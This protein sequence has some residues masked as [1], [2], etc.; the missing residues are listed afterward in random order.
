MIRH[1]NVTIYGKVQGVFFR[2]T[3]KEKADT[4][5]IKVS[6]ENK[7]DGT[8]YIEAEGEKEKLDEFIKWCHLGPSL[9]RVEKVE[10]A[11]SKLKNF[12]GFETF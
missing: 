8:V 10:V 9:A 5:G 7:P 12:S 1:I 2:V 11:E 3:A 6:A 4:L